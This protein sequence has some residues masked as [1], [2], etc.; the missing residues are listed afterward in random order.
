M[1]D[2]VVD[3]RNIG[4]RREGLLWCNTGLAAEAIR[5]AQICRAITPGLCDAVFYRS[6][7]VC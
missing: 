5:C 2:R 1:R 4:V 3:A 7:L 6:E